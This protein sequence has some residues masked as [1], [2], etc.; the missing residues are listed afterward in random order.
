MGTETRTKGYTFEDFCV[1]V[2]DGQKADLID[3]VIY[4]ASPDNNDA[5]RLCVWLLTL[6]E[7]FVDEKD[8]G[9]MF[10]NRSAFRLDESN[11]PEPD[12][13]FVRKERLHLVQ[14]GFTDGPPDLALEIVSPESVERDYTKKR[15]QYQRA[16]V[17]EYWIVDELEERL[18][19]LRLA[20]GGRYRE[21][22]PRKGVLTS[23]AMPGFWV[24]PEWL[25]QRPRPKLAAVLTLLLKS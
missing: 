25:W 4:M 23:E 8:L 14:R 21:V 20:S 24:R 1:L 5:N 10:V 17:L 9:D 22:R 11:S 15:L 6:M 13:A 12:V 3:G 18:T 16:G 2:K 7:M 19:L